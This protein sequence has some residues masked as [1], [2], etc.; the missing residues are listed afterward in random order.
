MRNPYWA[1]WGLAA[2]VLAASSVLPGKGWAIKTERLPRVGAAA[3]GA[4]AGGGTEVVSGLAFVRFFAGVGAPARAAALSSIGAG[5]A[6]EFDSIGWTLVSLASGVPVA[7]GLD[8]LQALPGVAEAAPD[9]A[10][11][12]NAVPNDPYFWSQYHLDRTNA[13]AGWNIETGNSN[14]VTIAIA[15]TGIDGTHPDLSP[16]IV[17]GKSKSFDPTAGTADLEDPLRPACNHAT[18]V[19]GV[20][21]AAANNN[22]GVAGVSWG[23]KLVSLK[24][25][26]DADC[27]GGC[28]GDACATDDAGIIAALVYAR[29]IH[30]T[31]GVGKL[32]FNLSIG[33]QEAC[34]GAVGTAINNAFGDGILIFAAAGNDAGNVQSPG[35]CAN[36][37]P[38]GAT[39]S[40]DNLASFSSRGAD[41]TARGVV[42][43]GV[44][45]VTSD[46][47][48]KFTGEA[49]GTSFSSPFVAG[50]AALITSNR[51]AFTATNVADAIRN[52]AVDLGAAGAD[53]LYGFGRVNVCRAL[54]NATG[55]VMTD[56]LDGGTGLAGFGDFAG[57]VTAFPNPFRVGESGGVTITL[58]DSMLGGTPQLKIYTMDGQLVRKLEFIGENRTVWDGK[59]DGG[60]PVATGTYIYHVKTGKGYQ[61]GRVAVIR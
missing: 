53:Q 2:A 11:R 50:L 23:A 56:C 41:M 30:N 19:A 44:N 61:T 8:Q 45:M 28:A 40:S 60:K 46:V 1:S 32:I 13:P 31:A 34:P 51:P 37:V 9:Q 6:K 49:L 47:G 58:P 10:Y 5:V 14:T 43:P 55:G 39:D 22:Y 3:Q 27:T 36:V 59:N 26:R 20:A 42:A 25:F 7:L 38:V 17:P 57:K 12:P 24:I 52:S 4:G 54:K 35:K 29:T 21:A 16:K 33:A 48:G 15:D 18:R